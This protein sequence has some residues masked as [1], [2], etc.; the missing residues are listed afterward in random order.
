MNE[1]ELIEN[2]KKDK[3]EESFIKLIDFYKDY[4]VKFIAIKTQRTSLDPN[5]IFS[6]TLMKVWV[7]IDSFKGDGQFKNWLFKITKNIIFDEFESLKKFNPN[8]ALLEESF[9]VECSSPSPDE[10]FSEKEHKA[11]ILFRIEMVKKSLSQK[12]QKVFELIFEQGKS[13]RETSEI[14]KCS[15]GTVMSR[16]HYTRRKMQEVFNK[17][18]YRNFN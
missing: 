5:E 18:E 14:L 8:P 1:S 16:V 2:F 7:K 11:L 12:H 4:L 10:E 17:Y 13:Y 15:V 6:K 9:E 3:S